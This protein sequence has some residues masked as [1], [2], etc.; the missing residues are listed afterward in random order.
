L[1]LL[2]DG[3]YAGERFAYAMG[4]LPNAKAGIAK[5]GDLRRFAAIPKRRIVD[6][7]L[8][9]LD[10]F[11]LLWKSGER[12]R[13]AVRQMVTFAFFVGYFLPRFGTGGTFAAIALTAGG[14]LVLVE[15]FF[16]LPFYRLR[17][18]GR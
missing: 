14:V 18:K 10:H 17:S 16:W 5:R 11:R 7:F 15:I 1:K 13:C 8:G 12:K 4:A 6:R 2:C 9:W 3:G